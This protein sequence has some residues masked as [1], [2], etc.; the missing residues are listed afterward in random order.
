MLVQNAKADIEQVRNKK[1]RNVSKVT[2]CLSAVAT[3]TSDAGDRIEL[4]S[5]AGTGSASGN[6]GDAQQSVAFL[7]PV[8]RVRFG[9]RPRVPG[10]LLEGAGGVPKRPG[11][12]ACVA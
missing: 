12:A 3:T 8:P 4:G 1:K 7:V 10:P 11:V 2:L 9:T 6:A 5:V